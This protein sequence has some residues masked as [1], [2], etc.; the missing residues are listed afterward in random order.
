MGFTSTHCNRLKA[1]LDINLILPDIISTY[2][3][4]FTNTYNK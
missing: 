3:S 4:V 1:V 2:Y